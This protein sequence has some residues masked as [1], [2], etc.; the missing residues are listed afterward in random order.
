[1]KRILHY[2]AAAAGIVGTLIYTV[3]AVVVKLGVGG[4]GPGA[5]RDMIGETGMWFADH[6]PIP[7]YQFA[8]IAAGLVTLLMVPLGLVAVSKG[9]G[10]RAAGFCSGLGLVLLGAMLVVNG[11]M[12]DSFFMT[13]EA[14]PGGPF[15][16]VMNAVDIV[17]MLGV[18]T[19][20]A[21]GIL[22]GV[23]ALK[24]YRNRDT[25]LLFLVFGM[26]LVFVISLVWHLFF[27]VLALTDGIL[28]TYLRHMAEIGAPYVWLAAVQVRVGML[29]GTRVMK[30]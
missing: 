9:R 4:L 26:T 3:F 15:Y 10:A 19:A 30:E 20:N 28:Y 24:E 29:A 17:L 5:L 25:L 6:F 7:M 12:Y 21:G 8:M 22:M 16:V 27:I 2:V 1:M 14:M 18:L 13:L 23:L 11:L